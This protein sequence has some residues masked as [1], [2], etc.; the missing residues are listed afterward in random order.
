MKMGAIVAK[1]SEED[2]ISIYDFGRYLG[3]AFQFQDDYLDAFGNPE[4]FG[5]QV[6]GDI[7]ENKKTYLYIK[8]IEIGT[9]DDIS[10]LVKLMASTTV[11]NNEKVDAVKTIFNNSGA[12]QATQEA[13]KVYT[14]KAFEVLNA[15]NISE[16]KKQILRLFGEQ[17]MNR[18]V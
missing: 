2:Q 1:A 6:G 16:D 15:L 7:L 8:T 10:R 5:K 4:T 18:R 17:L 14:Q 13:V 11:S 12:S 3:I 9:E